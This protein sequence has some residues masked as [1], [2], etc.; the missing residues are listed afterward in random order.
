MLESL[1]WNLWHG[2]VYR[3]LQRA[4]DLEAELECLETDTGNGK[5]LAKAVREF[6]GYIEANQ[7]FIPKYG[8]VI[9]TARRSQP[10]SWNRP[11]IRW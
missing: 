6:A 5:K 9:G 1:K 8:T 3:A 10:R 2:N 4:E 11:S 7:A